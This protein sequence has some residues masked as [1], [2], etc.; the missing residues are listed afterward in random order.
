MA[1][2][3]NFD[4]YYGLESEQFSFYR[5]PKMLMK[6]IRFKKLSSDAKLLY[7]LLLDR[8]S[9]SMKNGWLDSEN[10]VYIYYTVNDIMEDLGCSKASCTKIMSE[11]DS[12]KGIGLIEKKRQGLGKPDMIYVKNFVVS[13]PYSYSKSISE[14]TK[15]TD[16][17]PEVQSLNFRNNSQISEVIEPELQKVQETDFLKYENQTSRSIK[18]KPLEV[19]KLNPNYTDNN[20][21]DISYTYPT[22]NQSDKKIKNIDKTSEEMEG[23]KE[24][25]RYNI[26]YEDLC[27]SYDKP[28]INNIVDIMADVYAFKSDD[29]II[30]SKTELP[31]NLVQSKF[32]K[33]TGSHIIYAVDCIR[34]SSKTRKIKNIKKYLLT[35][36]YNAP[37]CMNI[38]TLSDMCY[39]NEK[40]KNT[41]DGYTAS[42]DLAAYEN[43]SALDEEW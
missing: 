18:I 36:L 16:I 39:E 15:N 38:H 19:Q 3:L 12:K 41:K 25:I 32:D 29:K 26:D 21:T 30:I 35:V 42:Y 5:I 27:N 2:T 37:K 43:T 11:L 34:E 13:E 4:Y 17:S 6:D 33:I 24:K 10:K 9:L 23:M 28:M 14:N 31:A 20:Y 40:R 7:G 22:I 1:N 8:M